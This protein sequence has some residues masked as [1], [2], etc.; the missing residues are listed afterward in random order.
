MEAEHMTI[1]LTIEES[2]NRGPE[3]RVPIMKEVVSGLRDR[4]NQNR[5]TSN[6]RLDY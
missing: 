6:R 4:S 3:K 2:R 1:T 5:L